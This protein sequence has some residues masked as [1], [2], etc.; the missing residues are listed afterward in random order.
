MSD[1]NPI[2]P[3]STVEGEPSQPAPTPA[4]APPIKTIV[5]TGDAPKDEWLEKY[6]E[7]INRDP[8]IAR[9]YRLIDLAMEDWKKNI[10][11]DRRRKD[12]IR[13]EIRRMQGAVTQLKLQ[14]ECKRRKLAGVT[15][16]M[17][18]PRKLVILEK[19]LQA[20]KKILHTRLARA[21]GIREKNQILK[22][23]GR[24]YW[25]IEPEYLKDKAEQHAGT[26]TVALPEL[27]E[28]PEL[29]TDTPSPINQTNES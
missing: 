10:E 18:R 16:T 15:P 2:E 7:K 26:P 1:L 25:M 13:A 28:L 24:R 21:V 17:L 23:N 29:P 11:K 4:P 20:R 12:G 5:K 3:Q 9:L 6:T 8:T 14:M 27:P 22:A 19:Q